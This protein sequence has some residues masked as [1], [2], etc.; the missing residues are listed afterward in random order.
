MIVNIVVT[1]N[2]H[3]SPLSML[4]LSLIQG[5]QYNPESFHG[6]IIPVSDKVRCLCF[7]SGK[8]VCVGGKSL[9]EVKTAF[10]K[11]EE[12]LTEEGHFCL[13]GDF[14]IQNVVASYSLGHCVELGKLKNNSIN[15][16]YEP[17]LFPGLRY[18][19][20]YPQASIVVFST[21]KYNITGLKSVDAAEIS[22][23]NFREVI[24]RLYCHI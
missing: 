13:I 12:I 3:L 2:L 18:R 9:A 20:Q 23:Q 6:V 10:Q 5:A 11:L 24:N 22:S 14:Q 7:E 16:K 19:M 21:G 1:G 15:A 4:E 17:E 8:V